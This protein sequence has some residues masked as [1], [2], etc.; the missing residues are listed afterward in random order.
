MKRLSNS[1]VASSRLSSRRSS[2][3]PFQTNACWRLDG[4]NVNGWRHDDV[5]GAGTGWRRESN[6]R[7]RDDDDD[8]GEISPSSPPFSVNKRKKSVQ[9]SLPSTFPDDDDDDDNDDDL[10]RKVRPTATAALPTIEDRIDKSP[11]I[12]LRNLCRGTS[13]QRNSE[14][15][16][17]L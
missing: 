17:S 9:F 15:G 4:I 5:N 13:L 11:S 12:S 16:V 3:V 6:D 2:I 8:D 1:S 7:W 14:S 10:L